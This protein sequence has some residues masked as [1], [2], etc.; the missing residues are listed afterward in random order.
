MNLDEAGD[1]PGVDKLRSG[2]FCNDPILMD[3][4]QQGRGE[5]TGPTRNAPVRA[6]YDLR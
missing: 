1:L 6:E 3:V 2:S 4:S 5:E